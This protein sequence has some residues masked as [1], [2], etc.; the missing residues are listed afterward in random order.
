MSMNDSH[1]C[2]VSLRLFV[3]IVLRNMVLL[4]NLICGGT[5]G[6]GGVKQSEAGEVR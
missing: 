2:R 6:G 5:P 1:T 3:S 4:K